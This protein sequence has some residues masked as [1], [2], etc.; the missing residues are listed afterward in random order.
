VTLGGHHEF[1][2]RVNRKV[3]RT[4][5]RGDQAMVCTLDRIPVFGISQPHDSVVWRQAYRGAVPG[6]TGAAI[7]GDCPRCQTEARSG[8]R[9]NRV[10]DLT[11]PPSNRLEKLKGDLKDFH[12]IRINDQ[13]RVI[14]KWVNKEPH[15]VRI[16]DYH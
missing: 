6:R 13:W 12:L 10:D 15:E 5:W 3:G 14:F 8:K 1:R 16:V 2:I 11:V 4:E 7:L 9:R